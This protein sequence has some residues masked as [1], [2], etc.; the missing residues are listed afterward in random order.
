M[1][2]TFAETFYPIR[3][4]AKLTGVPLDTIRAWERRYGAVTPQRGARGRLYSEKE[5]QRLKL[6]RDAVARGH[7]IG[8]VA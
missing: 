3:A 4:V 6:L 1:R 8:Q 5:V 7:S 2:L